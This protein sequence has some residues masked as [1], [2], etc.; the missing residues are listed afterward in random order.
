MLTRAHGLLL[1]TMPSL[2]RKRMECTIQHEFS[3][4]SIDDTLNGKKIVAPFTSVDP[5]ALYYKNATDGL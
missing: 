3:H 5:E 1:Y 4:G 2:M